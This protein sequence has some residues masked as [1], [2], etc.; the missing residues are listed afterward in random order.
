MHAC[1]PDA[2]FAASLL[3]RYSSKQTRHVTKA[4]IRLA[5]YLISTRSMVLTFRR[6]DKHFRA[7]ADSSFA[8]DPTRRSWYCFLLYYGGASF[9]YQSKLSRCLAFL[10]EHYD[11]SHAS[12]VH[13][14]R[15]CNPA[16]IGTKALVTS[17]DTLLSS[18]A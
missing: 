4:V 7:Y 15:L 5:Q 16:D 13:I 8:N 14:S 12:V 2:C 11:Q 3:A 1:R 18:S 17:V 10:R 6:D 9:D